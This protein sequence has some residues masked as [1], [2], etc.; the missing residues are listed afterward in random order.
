MSSIES[1]KSLRVQESSPRPPFQD[2][3]P[4]EVAAKQLYSTFN[5]GAQNEHPFKMHVCISS[6][7]NKL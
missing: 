7:L 1:K 5:F 3:E 4:A 2:V 6:T